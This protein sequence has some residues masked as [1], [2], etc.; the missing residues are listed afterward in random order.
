MA[1]L[2]QVRAKDDIEV[3]LPIVDSKNL[4]LGIEF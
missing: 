3:F 4:Y 1:L 2:Y